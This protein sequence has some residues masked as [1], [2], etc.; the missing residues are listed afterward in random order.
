MKHLRLK[1]NI[2]IAH[3]IIKILF[4]SP[5]TFLIT[6]PKCY[7][8][9]QSLRQRSLGISQSQ[10]ALNLKMYP[11]RLSSSPTRQINLK[12]YRGIGDMN[13]ICDTSN[14][15][16][17]VQHSIC[18]NLVSDLRI[19]VL[20]FL[21]NLKV[22]HHQL[23]TGSMCNWIRVSTNYLQNTIYL[24]HFSKLASRELGI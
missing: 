22:A 23:L 5:H 2:H 11:Q 17:K 7:S 14:K 18:P 24:N 1:L 8:N 3:F 15:R 19:I 9:S 21:I 4:L 20:W 16:R 13:Q 10:Q 12:K 6:F